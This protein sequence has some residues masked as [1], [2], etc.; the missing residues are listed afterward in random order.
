[1]QNV[2]DIAFELL[3]DTGLSKSADHKTLASWRVMGIKLPQYLV[4]SIDQDWLDS[5]MIPIIPSIPEGI[6]DPIVFAESAI[7]F[8]Y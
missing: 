4:K 8:F 7:K 1:M 5:L 3:L 6:S 2:A